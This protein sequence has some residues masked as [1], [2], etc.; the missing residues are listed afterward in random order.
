MSGLDKEALE[1]KIREQIQ[2]GMI[3]Q[4]EDWQPKRQSSRE[5]NFD[6]EKTEPKLEEEIEYVTKET[7]PKE[8]EQKTLAEAAKEEPIQKEKV[9]DD[10]FQIVEDIASNFLPYENRSYI[11]V[12][13]FSVT[14]L[15]L[16]ARSIETGDA[17]FITQ[18]IDNC[19][20]MPVSQLTIADYFHLYYWMR[21]N[22][23]PNTPHYMEWICDEKRETGIC[24]HEN[25]TALTSKELKIVY[26]EYFG[27]KPGDLDPRLDFPR[28]HLLQDLHLAQ[29]SK[30]LIKQGKGKAAEF[31][32]DDLVLINAAKWLKEGKTL[33]DKIKILEKEP[34]LELYEL[35]SK[36]NT[37]Y[38][39]G[40]YEYAF[41]NCGRCGAKRRYRVLLDA[42]RFFPFVD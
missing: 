14:E 39:Y 24:N 27:Y 38:E 25:L 33:R 8:K 4:S 21:I 23:Y 3:R 13:P 9:V 10:R 34:N 36:A 29:Q 11:K 28:V 6:F 41:V 30:D 2:A 32:L 15:K 31:S 26:L 37:A 16:I 5:P 1:R 20:D 19:I 35:A 42:P 17:D 40:V 7:E 22:S 18:A 12:R